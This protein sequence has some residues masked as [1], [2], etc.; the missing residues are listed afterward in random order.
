MSALVDCLGCC[1][2]MKKMEKRPVIKPE[3]FK[4]G[5][6]TVTSKKGSILTAEDTERYTNIDKYFTDWTLTASSS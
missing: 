2:V 5:P 1:K 4:F 3:I 6:W